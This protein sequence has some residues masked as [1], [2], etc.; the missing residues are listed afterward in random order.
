M[1]LVLLGT[2]ESQTYEPWLP[3]P[4]SHSYTTGA[5]S[6]LSEELCHLPMGTLP[7]LERPIASVS[8]K[9]PR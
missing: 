6:Y 4:L 1:G 8:G 7:T 3:G 5:G 9:I 2:A